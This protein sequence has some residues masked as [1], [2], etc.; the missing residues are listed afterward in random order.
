M[1]SPNKVF[2]LL[3]EL[4]FVLLGV[5]LVWL[6]ATGRFAGRFLSDRRSAAWIGLGAFLIYW[7]LR[8]W[9]QM[10]RSSSRADNR[11]PARP[12]LPPRPLLL[13]PAPRPFRSAAGPRG[14]TGAI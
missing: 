13:A 4:V 3:S 10:E 9:W 12:P 5:L 7:G 14:D 11:A 2:R 6:A 8:A 1:L